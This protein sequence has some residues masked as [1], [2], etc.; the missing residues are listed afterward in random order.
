MLYNNLNEKEFEERVDT[1]IYNTASLCSPPE[2][3][4]AWLINYAPR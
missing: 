1:S 4:T 2:A 3:N